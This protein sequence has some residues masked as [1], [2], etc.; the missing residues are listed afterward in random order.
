MNYWGQGETYHHTPPI[1]LIYGFAR[2]APVRAGRGLEKR[3]ER[4]SPEPVGPGGRLEAMGLE[5]FVTNPA[6]RLVTVTRRYEFPRVSTSKQFAKQLLDEFDI[7]IAQWL[8]SVKGQIWR[9]GLNG[10]FLTEE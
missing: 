1:S 9:G 7:E 2:S 10:I 3:I 8:R 5:M 6:D 4:Q